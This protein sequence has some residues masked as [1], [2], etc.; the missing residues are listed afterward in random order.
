M[1]KYRDQLLQTIMKALS[2]DCVEHPASKNAPFGKGNRE[3]LDYVLSVCDSFNMK[4]KNLDGFCGIAD[5]GSGETFGILGHLDV[6]P[7]GKGWT[8]NPLGEIV[9]NTIY[10]RGIMDDKGP[11]ISCMFA[12]KA[13][14]DEGLIP[15]RT[16]RLIFGCNEESGWK[17]IEHYNKSE[18]MPETGFSPDSDFPVINC[19]KGIV[20]YTLIKKCDSLCTITAGE[21]PNIVPNECFATLPMSETNLELAKSSGLEYSVSDNLISLT[22]LGKSAHAATPMFGENAIVKMLD[23]LSKVDGNLKRIR[24]AFYTYSG[25]GCNICL[26]DEPSGS[27][28]VN[29]GIINLS[30]GNLSFTLDIRYPV[31]LSEADILPNIKA[32]FSDFKITKPH[33]H[34]PLYVDKSDN[35]VQTLLLTYNKVTG[36]NDS[37]I[38]IGGG[39]Y[40][41]AMKKGVAFGP[42]FANE[43][44]TIHQPDE[45]VSIDTLM[46][47]TKIY[48]EAIKVLCF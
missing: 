40:A 23:V 39:T 31:T 25:E 48:Y 10:G 18:K 16:I 1:E 46:K 26:S 43:P 22:A 24:D 2:F 13:L 47:F 12:I 4:T 15:K 32:K 9:D 14:L 3:C 6:V 17:C 21:R 44:D 41:R 45:C 8:K 37:P 42:Q 35:L 19:E 11:M 5:V 7:F 29:L 33:F 36:S 20:N 27:L 38:S 34:L 30:N 28:T